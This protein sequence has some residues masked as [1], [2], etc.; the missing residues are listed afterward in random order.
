MSATADQHTRE[1]QRLRSARSEREHGRGEHTHTRT[2][3]AHMIGSMQIER[4]DV[5]TSVHVGIK[6]DADANVKRA[7]RIAQSTAGTRKTRL[8]KT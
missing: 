5:R 1:A 2:H 3:D 7:K 4:V 6:A 8:R